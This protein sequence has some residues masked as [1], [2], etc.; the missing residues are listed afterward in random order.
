MAEKSHE[1]YSPIPVWLTVC[2]P[3]KMR[4]GPHVQTCSA[5]VPNKI[6]QKFY[7]TL[8]QRCWPSETSRCWQNFTSSFPLPHHIGTIKV[9]CQNL[10]YKHTVCPMINSNNRHKYRASW[11]LSCCNSINIQAPVKLCQAT[12]SQDRMMRIE[13]A[14]AHFTPMVFLHATM[15]VVCFVRGMPNNPSSKV[16]FR[17]CKSRVPLRSFEKVAFWRTPPFHNVGFFVKRNSLESSF[18]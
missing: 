5:I 9:P 13:Y 1:N 8:F 2:N 7:R 11:D 12:L 16:T 18:K 15:V 4:W 17:F 10:N 6:K 14:S 3:S